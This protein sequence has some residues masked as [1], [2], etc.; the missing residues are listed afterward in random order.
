M[1]AKTHK[2]WNMKAELPNHRIVSRELGAGS[3]EPEGRRQ[4]AVVRRQ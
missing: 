4:V 2:R 1:A 3:V